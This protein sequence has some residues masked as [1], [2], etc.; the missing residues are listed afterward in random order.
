MPERAR[1]ILSTASAAAFAWV[2]AQP[3]LL[4]G[5]VIGSGTPIEDWTVLGSFDTREAC[6]KQRTSANSG[7]FTT[8]A[9]YAPSASQAQTTMLAAASRCIEK[10]PA[11]DP[12]SP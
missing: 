1:W 8:M 5:G 10:P 9:E 6:E 3:P 11:G 7:V 12:A 4:P 2:L